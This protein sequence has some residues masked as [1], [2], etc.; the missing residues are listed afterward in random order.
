MINRLIVEKKVDDPNQIGVLFPSL[1]WQGEPNDKVVELRAAL[2]KY[3]IKV[4]APRA[5][6]FLA[7]EEAK[8]VFGVLMHILGKPEFDANLSGVDYDNYRE[9]AALIQSFVCSVVIS[10]WFPGHPKYLIKYELQKQLSH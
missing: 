9:I 8:D 6:R 3:G 5:G 7:V 2:A 4:Y 1:Q 10:Y